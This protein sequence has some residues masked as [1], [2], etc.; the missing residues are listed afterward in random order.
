MIHSP[1][2]LVWMAHGSPVVEGCSEAD[3]LCYVCGGNVARG[4]LVKKWMSAS[5]SDHA[6]VACPYSPVVCE[7]CV[8]VMSRTTPVL[9]RPAGRCSVCEGTLK[10]VKVPKAGKGS[11][12]RKGDDCPKCGG[13]GMNPGGSNFRN[14]CHLWEDGWDSPAFAPVLSADKTTVVRH[15]G[16]A[17]LGYIN[18]NKGEKTF[19][20]AF[21]ERE[22]TGHWF[23]AIG[24]TGQ[25]HVLPYAELNGPGRSGVVLFE[26]QTVVVPDD[27]SLIADAAQLLTDGASKE[28]I[29]T[30]E[31]SVKA[32]QTCEESIRA[33]E[34]RYRCHR[35][36]P[37]FSLA[38][39]V[40]QQDNEAVER[41][42]AAEKEARNA[43]RGKPSKKPRGTREDRQGG[44]RR[45]SVGAEPS[46]HSDDGAQGAE[47]LGEDAVRAGDEPDRSR[48][49]RP[50]AGNDPKRAPNPK[51]EQL[52]LFGV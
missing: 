16:P 2:Q 15:N 8:H 3:G 1:P 11:K 12:A 29:L 48:N 36:S 52:P 18:A 42:L 5:F 31:Y 34:D 44:D 14:V 13:T 26:R 35:G 22:H 51:P 40:A 19:I 43:K 50:V 9:G 4:M 25:L 21:L 30:G 46:V 39:W 28:Q 32:W 10:V 45:G 20:R 37:W 24:D 6:R 33:F 7:A 49:D 47:A 27:V 38:I 23:A 17:G 41:R